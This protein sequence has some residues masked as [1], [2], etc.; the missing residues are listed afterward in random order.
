MKEIIALIRPS[1]I[2]DTKKALEA[3]GNPEFTG[4]KVMGKGKLA[5]NI[6]QGDIIISKS[7]MVPKR[8]FIIAVED[9][10][11][12]K[13]VNTIM[14]VNNTG[15]PGDGKIFVLPITSSYRIRTGEKVC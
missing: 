8:M 5:V 6:T 12:E 4:R 9:K 13:V 14:Y 10:D 11:V 1:K 15:M 3:I 2:D 7:N